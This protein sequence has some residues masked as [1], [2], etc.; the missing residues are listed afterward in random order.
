MASKNAVLRDTRAWLSED[1]TQKATVRRLIATQAQL[2]RASTYPWLVG[3]MKAH[4]QQ[5]AGGPGE[6]LQRALLEAR[7]GV[8][9]VASYYVSLW[10]QV[11]VWQNRTGRL[12]DKTVRTQDE[13]VQFMCRVSALGYSWHAVDSEGQ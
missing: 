13:L 6:E 3:I 4:G 2:N 5:W 10:P 9:A 7:F 12:C 11:V 1:K 8:P